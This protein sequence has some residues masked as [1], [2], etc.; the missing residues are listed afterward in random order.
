ML[1]TGRQRQLLSTPSPQYIVTFN[2]L[3]N[4]FLQ[5]QKINEEFEQRCRYIKAANSMQF[6][7]P[8]GSVSRPI[9]G[10]HPTLV[11]PNNLQFAPHRTPL[12]SNYQAL[13]NLP[14]T[15]PLQPAQQQP[16]PQPQ[17][18][19]AQA[20]VSLSRSND[21]AVASVSGMFDLFNKLEVV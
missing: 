4:M 5:I 6:N 16:Q 7:V 10:P 21:V 3:H 12:S 9:P 15:L 20:S 13:H 1:T 2:T 11:Q 14:P 8:P 18:P 19:P 17:P